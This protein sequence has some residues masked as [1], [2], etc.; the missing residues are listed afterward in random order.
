MLVLCYGMIKKALRYGA[1]AGR[2]LVW[3]RCGARRGLM[4]HAITT[5]LIDFGGVIAEEGFRDG[6]KAIGRRNGLDPDAFFKTVDGLIFE[7]GY[8]T[9]AAKE[10]AFWSAVRSRTGITE[11]DAALRREI[12]GRFVLRPEMIALVDRWRARGLVVAM[13]S[14]QTD[15]LEEIDRKTGLYGHFDRVFN[16]FRLGKSKRDASIFSDVCGQLG[17]EPRRTLFI[18]DNSE[19]I[20]RARG[21]GLAVIHF[22]DES[23]FEDRVR[24]VLS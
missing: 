21:R 4:M 8:L 1:V 23:D 9:G 15:W 20:E 6:L 16:S 18:D 14:D 12:L 2:L 19:H 24:T 22:T 5:I 13:L 17:A 11:D 10:A 3:S 7:T